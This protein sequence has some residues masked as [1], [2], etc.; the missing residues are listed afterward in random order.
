LLH[1]FALFKHFSYLT[2]HNPKQLSTNRCQSRS[3]HHQKM[4]ENDYLICREYEEQL[5]QVSSKYPGF[6]AYQHDNGKF[7]FAVPDGR[8]GILL[9]SEGYPNESA[10]DN[11]IESVQKNL[12]LEERYSIEE[13]HG[14]FFTILKAG[15]HQ[16][17]ARSCPVNSREE[18]EA[19][20]PSKRK[21]AMAAGNDSD[22]REDN[23]LACQVYR[24]HLGDKSEKYP[25]F[26]TFTHEDGQH[27]FG[28][29]DAKGELLFRSEGYPT[30]GARD[31]GI[32][33]VQKNIDLEER[34]STFDRGNK[35]F[36]T[37]KAGNH[38]EIA[39][40]CPYDTADAAMA[41]FPSRRLAKKS[42]SDRNV[43]EYLDCD[44]YQAQANNKSDKYPGFITFQSEAGEHYFAL[45]DSKGEVMLRSEG[46]PTTGARDNGIQSVQKNMDQEAR[47]ST[48]E[49]E[50]KYFVVLKAGNHQEI[51]RS[52]PQDSAAAAFA[53]Y[54]SQRKL[55]MAAGTDPDRRE[56]N[57]LACKI[58]KSH[59]GDKSDKYPGFI[60]F[61]HEDGQHYFGVLNAAGDDLRFRSEG[62]PT[63]SARDN[64]IESVQKNIDNEA[65]FST[66]ERGGK[67]FV[68]LKAGNHQEIARSCPYDDAA[69]AAGWFPGA[70]AA[71]A[72]LA[73]APAIAAAMP[74]MAM[75]APEVE[76][77]A[78]VP[79]L[80]ATS[81]PKVPVPTPK[82]EAAYTPPIEAAATGG[83][84][85]RWL[86][87]LL[88]ALLLLGLLWLLM[89]GCKPAAKVGGSDNI[90]ANTPPPLETEGAETEAEVAPPPPPPVDL[91][92]DCGQGNPEPIMRLKGISGAPKALKKLGSNPEF[93]DSHGL[94]SAQFY[95]KLKNAHASNAVDQEFLDRIFK[96][97]GYANG[98]A[99]A[100]P[101]QFS[102]AVIPFGT[103]CNIGYSKMHKTQYSVLN[104]GERDQQAFRIQA[105]NGCHMHFMKTC[106]NHMFMGEN[107]Q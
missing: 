10:R 46:Y 101:E 50:G 45:L 99:D 86:W 83:G 35:Y 22:R 90:E 77:V 20:F 107:C 64:G 38:Q 37:L 68:V 18:A 78:A 48:V 81:A 47:Y 53:L 41:L 70:L 43:D 36:V 39:R 24:D 30:T 93:G 61:T 23:Y 72:A 5:N 54:P 106:G 55:A 84:N 66:F 56:D 4:N 11:G 95:D 82:I 31:N 103:V 60:T 15:N 62:Y 74:D 80:A 17:I 21:L 8:G 92:C 69:A 89:R 65:R 96:A 40:S 102:E 91:K 13:A 3:Q 63:T 58:Y 25:G 42:G 98:F 59:L 100:K 28:V 12:E 44:A 51:A 27:Y 88:G 97:M 57:Y 7:Y 67:H 85:L 76:K 75:P 87:W 9:R 32:Q 19:M 29:L 52:C 105:A 1:Q 34:Y 49:D 16:E 73:A 104:L 33:S 6:I 71:A 79:E 14:A 94:T 2:W 26:I